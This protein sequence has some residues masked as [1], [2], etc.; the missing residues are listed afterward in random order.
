MACMFYMNTFMSEKFVQKVGIGLPSIK[1]IK[2]TLHEI[3]TC[4]HND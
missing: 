4:R 1:T 2:K 3:G